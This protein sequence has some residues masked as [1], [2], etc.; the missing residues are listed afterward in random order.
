MAVATVV[1]GARWR[2]LGLVFLAAFV[3]FNLRETAR[4]LAG[5]RGH[6]A[7]AVQ[8]MVEHTAG[9]TIVALSDHPARTELVLNFYGEH[10]PPGRR[11]LVADA[12]SAAVARPSVPPAWV[13]AHGFEGDPPPGDTCTDPVSGAVFHLERRFGSYGLSGYSWYLF[14]RKS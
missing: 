5:T 7:E 3:A 11:L 13:V 4:S 9:D 14:H 10:L 1:V 8:Y 12:N 2:R 6:Y